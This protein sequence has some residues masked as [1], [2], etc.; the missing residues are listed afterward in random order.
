MLPFR[1]GLSDLASGSPQNRG[2]LVPKG[3]PKAGMQHTGSPYRANQQNGALNRIHF[4]SPNGSSVFFWEP[5]TQGH[6]QKAHP[7]DLF[8]RRGWRTLSAAGHCRGNRSSNEATG[9]PG[10]DGD[11]R[12]FHRCGDHRCTHQSS[13]GR[14][15]VASRPFHVLLVVGFFSRGG[16]YTSF[17]SRC[18]RFSGFCLFLFSCPMCFAI[19]V[20]FPLI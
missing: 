13:H 3:K 19:F 6:P 16:E 8:A 10:E 12:R 7:K 15:L 4:G 2:S 18:F 14:G 5:K 11:G 20:L 9:A 17:P 1:S